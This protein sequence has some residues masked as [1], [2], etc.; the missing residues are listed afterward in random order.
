MYT[1][2]KKCTSR[3]PNHPNTKIINTQ[4]QQCVEPSS[5]HTKKVY[6]GSSTQFTH[7]TCVKTQRIFFDGSTDALPS[8]PQ[9]EI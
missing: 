1:V 7:R 6:K 5:C 3:W 8:F 2:T 4:E 9:L